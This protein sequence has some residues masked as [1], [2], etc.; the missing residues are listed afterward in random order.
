MNGI[1]KDYITTAER[2]R[3]PSKFDIMIM[4]AKAF[5]EYLRFYNLLFG[6]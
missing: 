1:K 4:K 6:S 2:L 3:A 5:P